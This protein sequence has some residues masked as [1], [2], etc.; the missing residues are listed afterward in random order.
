M[1][2][3]ISLIY[4]A[5]VKVRNFLYDIGMFTSRTFETPII[6]I[7]N[8]SVGGTGKT[9]MVEYLISLLSKD[10]KIAV[11]SR[12]YKRKSYGFILATPSSTVSELGDEPYQI[13]SKFPGVSVA[14]A[15]DRRSGISILEEKV[16]PD[17]ILLDDAFQH[18]K[19]K[20]TM[21]ILL[22]SYA[23]LFC[24]DWYLPTGNLRDGKKEARRAQIIIVTKC[25]ETLTKSEQL[26]IRKKLK[27]EPA[28]LLLFSFLQYDDKLSGDEGELTLISL[29][30][31]KVTLVTGIADPD[32]LVGYLKAQGMSFEHVRFKDHHNFTDGEV[33]TLNEKEVILTTEKDY[34]RLEGK[35]DKLYYVG[36]KHSFF[37]GGRKLLDQRLKQSIKLY[38]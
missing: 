28:Q 22:T 16:K 19:V 30:H 15:V 12:G 31:N 10:F 24:D 5:V 32:P 34:V 11:L 20:P 3:P 23:E 37:N 26:N 13:H 25:P 1:A 17:V 18:R 29:I 8:L 4:A 35:V 2:F 38:R 21:S 27:P 36:V 7:G 9:P 33:K 6:C 14:V